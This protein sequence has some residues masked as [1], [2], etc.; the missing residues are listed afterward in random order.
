MERLAFI[1]ADRFLV[2]GV[3]LL[4][5]PGVGDLDPPLQIGDRL[6][7]VRPDGSE[8]TSSVRSLHFVHA[9]NP[10]LNPFLT[11]AEFLP[12]DVPSGTAIW[13]MSGP[14]AG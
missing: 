14:E 6:R 9:P 10:I 7:L 1:V 11:L 13:V 2:K 8:A 12:T 5:V 3:G 4:L